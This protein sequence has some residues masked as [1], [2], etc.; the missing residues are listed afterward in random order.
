MLNV[1]NVDGGGLGQVGILA[2][3]RSSYHD[4]RTFE[5]ACE[6][7]ITQCVARRNSILAKFPA[8]YIIQTG[9]IPLY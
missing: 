6:A 4:N 8:I 2:S 7:L 1:V 9:R 5:Y 3:L